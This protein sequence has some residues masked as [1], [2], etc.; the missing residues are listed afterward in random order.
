MTAWRFYRGAIAFS[1]GD[2]QDSSADVPTNLDTAGGGRKRPVFD[3][4]GR[5]FVECEP[6]DLSRR[7]I[8]TQPCYAV[9]GDSR[10]N[11]VR[12]VREVGAHQLIQPNSGPLAPGQQFLI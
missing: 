10:P 12:Q 7:C 2:L 8:K 5:K 11:L 3:G 9:C 4:V 6:D 1:P